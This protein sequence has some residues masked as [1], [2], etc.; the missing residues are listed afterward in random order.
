[1]ERIRVLVVDSQSLF[2]IGFSHI[3]EAGPD[4]TVVDEASGS[5]EKIIRSLKNGAAGKTVLAAHI[6]G[7]LVNEL[8]QKTKEPKPSEG[9]AQ[10]PTFLAQWLSNRKIT[11]RCRKT[12]G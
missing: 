2:R 5:K 10:V 11:L 12:E 4:I 7:T 8:R 1:V 6:S 3:L 9:E